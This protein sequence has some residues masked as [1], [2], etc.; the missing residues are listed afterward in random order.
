MGLFAPCDEERPNDVYGDAVC[1]GDE[2]RSRLV[3]AAPTLQRELLDRARKRRPF[4]VI[5]P[6]ADLGGA[7]A[8]LE[9][10]HYR[11]RGVKGRQRQVL[12]DAS[13]WEGEQAVPSVV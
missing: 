4:A 5:D 9:L 2:D 10:E 12:G 8:C 7:L 3:R 6:A 13:P 1:P 11:R